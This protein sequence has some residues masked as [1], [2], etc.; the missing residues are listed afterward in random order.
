MA[1]GNSGESLG[2]I[3][4]EDDGPR[5]SGVVAVAA[6]TSYT[7]TGGGSGVVSGGAEPNPGRVCCC[8]QVFQRFI[9]PL[10]RSIGDDGGAIVSAGEDW[11]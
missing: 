10:P 5:S 6:G 2:G 9:M 3:S 11:A 8:V 7:G 4:V 1:M